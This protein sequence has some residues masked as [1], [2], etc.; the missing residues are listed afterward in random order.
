MMTVC[1]YCHALITPADDG[2]RIA[3]WTFAHTSC[4]W[5]VNDDFFAGLDEKDDKNA[6]CPP[7]F[8]WWAV[9]TVPMGCR[10]NRRINYV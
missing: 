8:V 1:C 10:Q 2:Q 7:V 6:H 4:A 3:R 9:L 5:V